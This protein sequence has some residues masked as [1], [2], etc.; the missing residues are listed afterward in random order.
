MKRVFSVAAC[1]LLVSGFALTATTAMAAPVVIGDNYTGKDDDGP[2]S[3]DT[4]DIV[5][6]PEFDLDHI[7]VDLAAGTISITGDYL[8]ATTN[9]LGTTISDLFLS[10]NG[11]VAPVTPNGSGDDMTSDNGV[12]WEWAIRYNGD[13]TSDIDLITSPTNPASYFASFFPGGDFRAGQEVFAKTFVTLGHGTTSWDT[14]NGVLTFSFAPGIFDAMGFGVG[15][16][17]RFTESCANDVIEGAV[18]SVPEPTSMLLLGT[19][20]VG[21]AGAARRRLNAR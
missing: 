6:G 7:T 17:V 11:Y 13:G 4:R 18:P 20:L 1:A 3:N 16:G 5:G 9:R 15:D 12:Q 8:K 10:T 2:A 21:L 14:T 19:G